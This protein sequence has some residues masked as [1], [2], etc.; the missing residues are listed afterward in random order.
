[1][2]PRDGKQVLVLAEAA[3][4]SSKTGKPVRIG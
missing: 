3:A 1:V 4:Q 2:G